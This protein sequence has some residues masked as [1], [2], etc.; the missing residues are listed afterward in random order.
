M[1]LWFEKQNAGKVIG[2]KAARCDGTTQ[3]GHGSRLGVGRGGF[4]KKEMPK[5][6]L[7]QRAGDQPERK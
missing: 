5:L 6:R 1:V 3:E 7:E 2:Q 4:L